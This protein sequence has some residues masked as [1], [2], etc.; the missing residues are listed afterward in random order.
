MVSEMKVA[1]VLR[2]WPLTSTRPTW[3]ML[4]MCSDAES[5]RSNHRHHPPHRYRGKA[6]EADYAKA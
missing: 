6:N 1:V 2:I 3:Q 4:E 5:N